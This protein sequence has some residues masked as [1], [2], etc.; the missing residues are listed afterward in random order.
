[1]PAAVA[2]DTPIAVEL[3]IPSVRRPE[4]LSLYNEILAS[5]KL[6]DGSSGLEN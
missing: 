5:I 2:G 4:F 3:Q 1:M 6:V